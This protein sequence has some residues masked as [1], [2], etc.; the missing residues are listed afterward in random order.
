MLE[1]HKD[2]YVVESTDDGN[3]SH[4]GLLV[5][6][7]RDSEKAYSALANTVVK[8]SKFKSG[9]DVVLLSGSG[10][11]GKVIG[12]YMQLDK[13]TRY[14]V[15]DRFCVHD[16][17][18]H[19]L[20]PSM[21]PTYAD[22]QALQ[23]M[24]EQT[25]KEIKERAYLSMYGA[26]R[27]AVKAAVDK[28]RI[29]TSRLVEGAYILAQYGKTQTCFTVA[30]FNVLTQTILTH[31]YIEIP[32]RDV[33]RI[34]RFK[35]G[36]KVV[37]PSGHVGIVTG[38]QMETDEDAEDRYTVDVLDG[39]L[40]KFCE[41]ELTKLEGIANAEQARLAY[42]AEAQKAPPMPKFSI[43]QRVAYL[44]T[45]RPGDEYVITK[46]ITS[47]DG[48]SEVF[49]NIERTNEWGHRHGAMY[50][51]EDRLVPVDTHAARERKHL[52]PIP[53][54]GLSGRFASS[55]NIQE[56]PSAFQHPAAMKVPEPPAPGCFKP[57]E[58]KEYLLKALTA[59]QQS[60]DEECKYPWP[61]EHQVDGS[62]S[63]YA[64]SQQLPAVTGP[65][66]T[67]WQQARNIWN[68]P[69]YKQEKCK[70]CHRTGCMHPRP[71]EPEEEEE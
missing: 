17:L 6:V 29:D 54:L 24:A 62:Y 42:L 5:K 57:G 33:I 48:R 27:D 23:Q 45:S 21:R 39:M 58:V 67:L 52:P 40:D 51:R 3:P 22:A 15:Q 71:A 7:L 63:K 53:E 9:D 69:V 19:E 34:A 47:F 8:V 65:L 41:C 50:V 4:I 31:G 66:G 60:I 32:R 26:K 25:R 43:G 56:M 18:E 44:H 10:S 20:Q 64:E 68:A 46:A 28:P 35:D 61:P 38:I 59:G 11:S 14:S 55:P 16:V 49:Y 70:I 12:A 36:D 2:T 13:D 37:I 1:E 30:K